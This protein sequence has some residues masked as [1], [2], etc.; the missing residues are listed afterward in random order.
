MSKDDHSNQ[1]AT[2]NAVMINDTIEKGMA[3][4]LKGT[5]ATRALDL[6]ERINAATADT[7][8]A[9]GKLH[10]EVKTNANEKIQKGALTDIIY[11]CRV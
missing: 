11:D 3:G 1:M 4:R 6:K 9:L 2:T 5:T 8:E 7:G 10:C